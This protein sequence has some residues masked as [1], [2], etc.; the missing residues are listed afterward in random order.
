MRIRDG[1]R[2][3]VRIGAG[4]DMDGKEGDVI[5]SRFWGRLGVRVDLGGY[6]HA[7][8]KRGDLVVIKTKLNIKPVKKEKF[9]TKEEK[10]KRDRKH[11]FWMVVTFTTL[12]WVGMYCLYRSCN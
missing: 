7:F 8:V 3:Y 11:G 6:K 2:V 9:L 10:Y 12:F 4:T 1:D 5:E